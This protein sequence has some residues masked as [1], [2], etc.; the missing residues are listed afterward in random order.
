MDPYDEIRK[1]M[2]MISPVKKCPQCGR[3]TLEFNAEANKIV[4]TGCGFEK[5]LPK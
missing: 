1:N 3:L 4:C 5:S 2:E